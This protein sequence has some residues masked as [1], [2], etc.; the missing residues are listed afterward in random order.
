MLKGCTAKAELPQWPKNDFAVDCFKAQIAV[1]MDSDLVYFT[2]AAEQIKDPVMK[3]Y[4]QLF[5]AD[6]RHFVVHYLILDGP[7]NENY[8]EGMKILK[9]RERLLND[10]VAQYNNYIRAY[11]IKNP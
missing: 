9:E 1:G 3:K 7:S 2:T 11:A 4:V 6:C 5:L 8:N 10:L